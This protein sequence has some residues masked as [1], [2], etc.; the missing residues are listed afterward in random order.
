MAKFKDLTGQ[1]FGML[2]VLERDY[3]Y[4]KRTAWICKCDCGKI[5]SK[6]GIYLTTGQTKSCGSHQAKDIM[7]EKFGRLTVIK[8]VE[9]DKYQNARWL[10]KCDCGNYVERLGIEL[11]RGRSKSCGC[12]TK[13]L[14][15]KHRKEYA[16]TRDPLYW[17][18]TRIKARC[19]NANNPRYE[20][21]RW[22]RD[23]NV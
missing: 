17:R 15:K 10:C 4:K 11:R 3:S 16:F 14:R 6:I 7:N 5:I 23:Y 8:R 9:D 1:R 2:E 22:Q 18:Y 13:E 12:L 19:Y 20:D 21:Y